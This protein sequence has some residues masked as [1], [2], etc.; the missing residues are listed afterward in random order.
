MKKEFKLTEFT[1]NGRKWIREDKELPD[2]ILWTSSFWCEDGDQAELYIEKDFGGFELE[3]FSG[4]PASHIYLDE[5]DFGSMMLK[6]ARTNPDIAATNP[7][8]EEQC[9]IIAD[10]LCSLLCEYKDV[11]DYK[12]V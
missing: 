9:I 5:V 7:S 12:Q 4:I 1:I 8:W 2:H 6:V 11:S 3:C 10:Y